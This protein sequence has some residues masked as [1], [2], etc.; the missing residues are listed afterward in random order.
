MPTKPSPSATLDRREEIKLLGPRLVAYGTFLVLLPGVAYVIRNAVEIVVLDA[1]LGLLV[2]RWNLVNLLGVAIALG[3]TLA[4]RHVKSPHILRLN[5]V[6]LTLGL[7]ALYLLMGMT[8]PNDFGSNA[9]FNTL[10]TMMILFVRALLVPSSALT[11]GLIGVASTVLICSAAAAEAENVPGAIRAV[12]IWTTWGAATTAATSLASV[13]LVGMRRRSRFADQLGAY[14]LEKKLGAGG[15]GSVYLGRHGLLRMPAAIKVLDRLDDEAEK[16]FFREAKATAELRHPNTVRVYDFGTTASGNPYYVMEYVNGQNLQNYVDA[17][18][19]LSEVRAVAIAQQIAGALDEA[20]SKGLVHRDVKPT[21][22]MRLAAEASGT[23]LFWPGDSDFVKVVD[24]GLV[25]R[26]TSTTPVDV[27]KPGTVSGTPLYMAPEQVLA[28][29]EIS[30]AADTYAL[31]CVIF[32]L[33]TGAHLAQGSGVRDVVS[34]H[35]YTDPRALLDRAPSVSSSLRAA[36][37]ECLAKKPEERWPTMASLADALG[38]LAGL[39]PTPLRAVAKQPSHAP[40]SGAPVSE[41][42]L[43]VDFQHRF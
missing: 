10:S 24:F 30:S 22:V 11:S 40:T 25:R 28:P 23:D 6:V 26:A 33:V 39:S 16:R 21:N 27:S 14:Q 29:E 35:V 34:D 37:L 18:G 8:A 41:E 9:A 13:A 31:G 32:F 42:Q 2:A 3:A 4:L 12:T 17:Q 36:L 20:H 5:D 7:V 38:R 43:T 1:P 19:P 15:M